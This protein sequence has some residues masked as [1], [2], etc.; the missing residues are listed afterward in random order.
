M[1]RSLQV[2]NPVMSA[3]YWAILEGSKN[4]TTTI[5]LFECGHIPTSS[6]ATIRSSCSRMVT[7]G[8]LT[9]EAGKTVNDYCTYSASKIGIACLDFLNKNITE[10]NKGTF[11]G[12]TFKVTRRDGSP[13]I[14]RILP[15]P[16]KRKPNLVHRRIAAE[17]GI[18]A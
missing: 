10:K 3:I 16:A 6:A 13:P 9:K 7:H 15:A 17:L 18:A 11:I 5:D 8:L 4:G 12:P 1:C 2:N 14:N